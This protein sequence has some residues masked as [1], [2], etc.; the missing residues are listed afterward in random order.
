M[1]KAVNIVTINDILE[2]AKKYGKHNILS[3][4]PAVYRDNKQKNKQSKFD[5]TWVPF[6][7]KL[8]SGEEVDLKKIKY[9]KV[10][11]ASGAKLPSASSPDEAV[12]NLLIAFRKLTLKEILVGDYAPKIKED[13]KSQQ[14]ENERAEKEAT[15][16]KKNTDD[17]ND[18]MEA[19]D[20]SYQ[21]IVEELKNSKQLGF[22][23][24]K[25]TVKAKQIRDQAKKAKKKPEEIEEEV[26]KAVTVF[27]FRQVSYED[28]KTKQDVEIDTPLTRIKLMISDKDKKVG[29]QMY[30][31]DQGRYIFTPNVYN[32]RKKDKDGNPQIAR[33]K[34]NGK[35]ELLDSNTAQKFITYKSCIGGILDISEIVISKFGIS[36]F[37]RF[38]ETYVKRYKS[39]TSEPTFTAEEFKELQGSDDDKND[40]LEIELNKGSNNTDDN[41][42]LSDLE[43]AD[44]LNNEEELDEVLS[45]DDD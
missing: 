41:S 40:E 28:Q 38:K 3:W 43:E 20:L 19:I 36:L 35:L 30:S 32:A 44:N 21:H 31:R 26:N 4:N 29:T 33:V 5:C 22:T 39:T 37:N 1:S 7:L 18:A 13:E 9:M 16:L 34:V 11:T 27:S 17:F 45:S 8:V 2:S 24:N 42:G 15:I 12:K 25:D 23:L 14:E 10:I 6:K